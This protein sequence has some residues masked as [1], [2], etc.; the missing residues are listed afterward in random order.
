LVIFVL[1]NEMKSIVEAGFDSIGR[2]DQNNSINIHLIYYYITDTYEDQCMLRQLFNT[3]N[4]AN[5]VPTQ[6]RIKGDEGNFVYNPSN[7]Q[8][9]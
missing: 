4:F 9:I 6:R 5:T 2:V 8:V 1:E 3:S 7:N